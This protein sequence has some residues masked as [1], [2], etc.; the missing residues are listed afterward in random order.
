MKKETPEEKA[1]RDTYRAAKK[2][3]ICSLWLG[4]AATTTLAA[5]IVTGTE[6]L[7]TTPS[8]NRDKKLSPPQPG[9][10]QRQTTKNKVQI[11]KHSKTVTSESRLAKMWA[12]QVVI[13][14]VTVESN[15][16]RLKRKLFNAD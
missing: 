14:T 9:D 1:A 3:L 11:A 16:R 2:R 10:K 12:E 15:T 5:G 7:C 13:K 4:A 6:E 8:R